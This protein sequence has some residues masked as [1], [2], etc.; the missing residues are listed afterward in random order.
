[1]SDHGINVSYLH[2]K[3]DVRQRTCFFGTC[4]CSQAGVLRGTRE[5]TSPD[6]KK[7]V[8]FESSELNL[9]NACVYVT[10]EPE[11][12]Q[13]WGTAVTTFCYVGDVMDDEPN[14]SVPPP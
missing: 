9:D 2:L 6:I 5:D 11:L 12:M 8:A 14:G 13:S 10:L 1:M 7:M 3:V 4:F